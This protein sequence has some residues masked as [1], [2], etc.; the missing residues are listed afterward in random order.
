[1]QRYNYAHAHFSFLPVA[2]IVA[3]VAA[4][5]APPRNREAN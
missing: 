1:M 5:R 4:P 3:K 2:R